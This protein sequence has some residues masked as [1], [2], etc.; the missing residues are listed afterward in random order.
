MLVLVVCVIV[1]SL[2]YMGIQKAID[3]YNFQNNNDIIIEEEINNEGDDKGEITE[4]QQNIENNA[5]E[6]ANE[7][8]DLVLEDTE[9][10]EEK[11]QEVSSEET[12]PN[13]IYVYITGEI[14]NPG[15]LILNEGSRIVDAINAICIAEKGEDFER[16]TLDDLCATT[17]NISIIT[18]I[19][20]LFIRETDI[21][22]AIGNSIQLQVCS[23]DNKAHAKRVIE[24]ANECNKEV[25]VAKLVSNESLQIK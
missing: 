11:E 23:E 19:P 10:V 13:E 14:N 16:Y 20:Q 3:N 24:Q 12:E 9:N 4:P 21:L 15:V 22:N 8:I 5:G 17:L 6:I 7:E 18:T 1:V 25:T 2:V